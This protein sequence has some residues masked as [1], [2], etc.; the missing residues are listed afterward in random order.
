MLL[1]YVFWT[2]FGFIKFC[3]F[4]IEQFFN[5]RMRW[6]IIHIDMFQKKRNKHSS[7]LRDDY[8]RTRKNF[9][10]IYIKNLNQL[11]NFLSRKIDLS[12]R[13]ER[14]DINKRTEAPNNGILVKR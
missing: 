10:H 11:L 4:K 14:N 9:L 5:I 13:V 3:D 6:Y 2:Y 12:I 1:E 7:F 8:I